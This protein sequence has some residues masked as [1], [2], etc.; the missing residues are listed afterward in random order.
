MSSTDTAEE[1]EEIGGL[2]P[3]RKR[4]KKSHFDARTKEIILNIYK[5]ETRCAVI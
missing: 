3:P 2:S 1:F 5:H 4:P